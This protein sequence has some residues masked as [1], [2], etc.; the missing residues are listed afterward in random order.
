MTNFLI[1][2]NFLCRSQNFRCLFFHQV[3]SFIVLQGKDDLESL[4]EGGIPLDGIISEE[5]L[6]SIFDPHSEGHDGAL[7][8]SNNRIS[9][10]AAFLPLSNNFHQLGKLGTR[11]SAA[12]GLS[13][14]SDA[15]CLVISE[16]KGKISVCKDGRL[17]TLDSFS[18]LEKEIDK[19]IKEKF[20]PPPQNPLSRIFKKDL[21]LKTSA[22]ATASLVWF[23]SAYQAGIVQKT[24]SIPVTFDQIPPQLLIESY[25]PKEISLSV[26][27]RGETAFKNID[28]SS[29]KITL[30]TSSLQNG[31]NR[32]TINRFH[33]KQPLNLSVTSV[34]PATVLLT[35]K[36]YFAATVSIRVPTQGQVA[37]GYRLK[38][39]TVTPDQI[40]LWI[41]ETA[42]PPTEISTEAVDITDQKEAFVVPAKLIFPLGVK[43]QKPDIVSVNIAVSIEK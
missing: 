18:D 35:A 26:S 13:E 19:F 20:A 38:N 27:G 42:T 6:L 1:G 29:F 41:P 39:L 34:E 11:H 23:F 43:A 3:D 28:G 37:K 14:S 7:V 22:A 2:K 40:D 9:K 24:F 5:I 25:S 32:L 12:L 17:K 15:F 8:I 16:E 30:D 10:F 31:V 36:K 4:L 21:G 33:I